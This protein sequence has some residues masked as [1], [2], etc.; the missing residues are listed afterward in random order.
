[1]FGIVI[2]IR[3]KLQAY[4]CEFPKG[5]LVF[6]CL[7]GFFF[8]FFAFFFR[9]IIIVI[10]IIIVIIIIIITSSKLKGTRRA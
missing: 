2:S 7:F 4:I 5:K 6:F 3:W 10:V 1:M 9:F 8:F